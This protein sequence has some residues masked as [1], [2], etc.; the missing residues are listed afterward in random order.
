MTRR[1][2]IGT[3][4]LVVVVVVGGGFSVHSRITD[5]SRKH[6]VSKAQT[7]EAA[8]L[9]VKVLPAPR[10]KQIDPVAVSIWLRDYT[11]TNQDGVALISGITRCI[12]TSV[13]TATCTVGLTEPAGPDEPFS[14]GTTVVR[15]VHVTCAVGSSSEGFCVNDAGRAQAAQ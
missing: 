7:A 15:V 5:S 2:W 9:G 1:Q 13:V 8:A 4:V 14:R 12:R 11:W 6:D 10:P 3:A